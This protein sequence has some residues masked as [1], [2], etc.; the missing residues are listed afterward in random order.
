M[1]TPVISNVSV[2]TQA[3]VYFDGRCVSH[4]LSLPDGTKKSVG[5]VL[6][7]EQRFNTAQ[8]EVMECVAGSCEYR[9]AGSDAWQ[10]SRAGE[11]FRIPANA[12]FD[13]RVTEPYHYICHYG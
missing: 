6:P 1:T 11:S 13:I 5:V 8:A 3:N 12:Y 2:T 7:M 4:S 10:T 9:L